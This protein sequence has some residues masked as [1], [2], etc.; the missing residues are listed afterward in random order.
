[1]SSSPYSLFGLGVSNN[2]NPGRTNAMA[3]T[4]IAMSDFLNINTMNPAALSTL[5]KNNFVYD[6]GI[7]F[8]Y[9][10]L[11]EGNREEK[12][13]NSNFSNIS[14]AV[15]ASQYSAFGIS[16]KPKTNVGYFLTNIERSIEG[17]NQ[18]F[19]AVIGSLLPIL[20]FFQ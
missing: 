15:K 4:G 19:L 5:G 1:M 9:G 8:Q 12:R 17:S 20:H 13:F 11:N 6:L 16:L 14:L 2:L 7:K 3:N 18:I 10:L